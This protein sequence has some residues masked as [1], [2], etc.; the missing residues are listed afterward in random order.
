MVCLKIVRR[1]RS[2]LNGDTRQARQSWSRLFQ[3]VRGKNRATYGNAALYALWRRIPN[4]SYAAALPEID[5]LLR[6]SYMQD[7]SLEPL[8]L[9]FALLAFWTKS[10]SK[11]K[12]FTLRP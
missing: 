12:C 8:A 5:R 1:S 7:M 11:R 6:V 4:A 10:L 3:Q 9:T 2:F